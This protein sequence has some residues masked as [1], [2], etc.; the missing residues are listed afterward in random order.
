MKRSR[1]RGRK[2]RR[3]ERTTG[4]MEGVKKRKEHMQGVK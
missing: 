4:S 2:R 1:G 3:K